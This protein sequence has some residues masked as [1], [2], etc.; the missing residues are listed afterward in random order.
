MALQTVPWRVNKP[1]D[2][3]AMWE[4]VFPFSPQRRMSM[5]VGTA[6]EL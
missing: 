3:R 5:V 2:A 6:S 1:R 4:K